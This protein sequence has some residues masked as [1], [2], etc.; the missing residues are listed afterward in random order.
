MATKNWRANK[1][2]EK[3]FAYTS[4]DRTK[5]LL[6]VKSRGSYAN[7]ELDAKHDL[8]IWKNDVLIVRRTF[9]NYKTALT[10]AKRY[11]RTH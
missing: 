11:M 6:I 3:G 9:K 1:V 8:L 7:N 4:E 2:F 5:H 10:F